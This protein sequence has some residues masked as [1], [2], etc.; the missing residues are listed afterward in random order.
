[1]TEQEKIICDKEDLVA[2]ADRIRQVTGEAKNFNVP[3]LRAA[4]ISHIGRG[5]GRLPE[6]YTELS[7]IESDGTF[8]VDTG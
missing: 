6:D 8:H 5:T 3:E 4:A 1:M 2:I 7:Y